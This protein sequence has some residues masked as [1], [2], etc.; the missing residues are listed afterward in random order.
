MPGDRPRTGFGAGV[1]VDPSDNLYIIGGAD[2]RLNE[3]KEL[4]LFQLRDPYFKYC[5][6][7]GAVLKAGVA[8]VKSTIYLGCLDNFLENA[9]GASFRVAIEGPVSIQP[10]IVSLGDGKYSCSFTP[11]KMGTYTLSIVLQSK[12]TPSVYVPY[13]ST[14]SKPVYPQSSSRAVC[15]LISQKQLARTSRCLQRELVPTL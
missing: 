1:V 4:F 8:G 13:F 2:A 3:R 12:L 5:S 6:A 10:G 14:C 7:T 15:P 9:D 11:V